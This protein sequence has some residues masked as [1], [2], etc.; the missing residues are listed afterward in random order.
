[1]TVAD[2]KSRGNQQGRAGAQALAILATPLS[3]SLL[4]ALEGEAKT[5][6]DL[7]QVAGFPPPTTIRG[8]LR[9][10]ESKGL[11]ARSRQDGFPGTIS[12]ELTEGGRDLLSV[13]SAVEA[14]LATAPAAPLELGTMAAKSAVKA[15]VEGWATSIIRA[16]AAR[17]LSLTELD[18]LIAAVSYPSLERRLG[19]MWIAGLVEKRSI[20]GK[21]T[22]YA[23]NEWL[24]RAFAP[25][26]AAARWERLHLATDSAP[27]GPRDIEAAFLLAI[28][29]LKL[30][31][32]LSGS[33][34]MAV[35]LRRDRA[36]ALVGV[37]VELDEGRVTACTT[38]LEARPDTWIG[39]TV[40]AWLDEA[41]HGNRGGLE[42]GGNTSLAGALLDSLHS[43]IRD[44][45]GPPASPEQ[46]VQS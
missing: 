41:I 13:K 14:W 39:G 8:Q 18:N 15:L 6:V 36:D 31:R 20:P 24:R 44:D 35:E 43:A 40:G 38:R 9:T 19:A 1:L 21:A 4:E 33:C 28:P 37:M 16:L 17:P 45:S 22:P 29:V 2:V 34:R 25:I 10:L 3:I 46:T 12:F 11:V 30:P 32:S 26:L 7:R 27:L 5:L 42:L 23:A